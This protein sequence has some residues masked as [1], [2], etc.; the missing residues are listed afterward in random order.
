MSA[1]NGSLMEL[2]VSFDQEL[3]DV[4]TVMGSWELRQAEMWPQSQR[5]Y[6]GT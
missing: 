5:T 2:L 4:R 6:L 1:K 3:D